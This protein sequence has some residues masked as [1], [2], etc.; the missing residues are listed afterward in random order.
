[1][2]VIKY[3]IKIHFII[4]IVLKSELSDSI[5]INKDIP[6]SFYIKISYKNKENDNCQG[7]ETKSNK[8]KMIS[9]NIDLN[10]EIIFFK[11]INYE[12]GFLYFTILLSL[13]KK[14][15]RFKQTKI[16]ISK[17]NLDKR[18]RVTMDY[19]IKS[20][21]IF[22]YIIT[23][24][25]EKLDY[26]M[27]KAKEKRT[28][29]TKN[30]NIF[31]FFND[32]NEEVSS[33]EEEFEEEKE[34]E[35]EKIIE[36]DNKNY[37]ENQEDLNEIKKI[38]TNNSLEINNLFDDTILDSSKIKLLSSENISILKPQK[39][40]NDI[41][42]GVYDTFCQGFFIASFPKKNGKIIE[43]SKN[44]RSICGHLICGKLPSMEPEIIYKYPLEDTKDLE[45]NNLCAS[46]CFPTG[47]KVCYNQ[48][49]RSIYKF[50][51]TNIFNQKGKKYYLAIYHFYYQL[52]TVT[53]NKIYSEHP[54]K[55]YL[56]NF[57]NN[58]YHSDEEKEKLEKDL[59]ECQELGFRDYV[60]IPYAIILVSKYPYINQMK[61][62]LN[63]IFII[64]SN[65]K[66]ILK[67]ENEELKNLFKSIINNIIVYLIKVIPIP[68]SNT[69]IIFNLPFSQY[70]IK[71][72]SPNKNNIRN[73][74]DIN[75]LNLLK[76]FNVENIILIFKLMLFEQK[77]LFIDNDYNR[78][79]KVIESFLY[80]LYPIEWI[81]T[82]IP[83]MSHQMTRYLQTF[84]PFIN[85]ISE[86]LFNKNAINALNEN[87]DLV[88]EIYIT[89]GQIK[90][91]N[92]D[93][94]ENDEISEIPEFIY[95][96]LFNE[97]SDLKEI[98]SNL[99]EKEKIQYYK[100]IN[101]IFSNIFL[102][103]NCIMLYDFMDFIFNISEANNN[104]DTE[105]LKRII[106]KKYKR[107]DSIF[108][109]D[110]IDSQIFLY[111]LTNIIYNKNE[112]SLFIN[113]LRNIHEK[114]II[115]HLKDK[116]TTWKNII[117]KIQLKDITSN[118]K[119]SLFNIPNHLQNSSF[120]NSIKKTYIIDYEKWSLINDNYNMKN[121]D[122]LNISKMSTNE[123]N[124]T[125]YI[126]ESDRVATD[127]LEINNNYY[128]ND[129]EYEKYIIPKDNE[130]I[131]NNSPYKD[132]R[133][134]SSMF[135]NNNVKASLINNF[136]KKVEIKYISTKSVQNFIEQKS[137][138]SINLKNEL[139][140]TDEE[141]ENIE[142]NIKEC[143][144][145]LFEDKWDIP[146][147]ECIK[148]V[149]Y[150]FGRRILC[151]IIFQK[152]FKI[153]QIMNDKCFLSLKKIFLNSLISICNINEN[154]E[155]LDFAVKITQ[156]AFCYCKESN[157]NILLI[158]ELQS[159]L[160]KDYF[161]WI[162][163]N[164]WNTWQNIDNYFA[165]NNYRVY[166]DLIKCDFLFKLLRLKIDKEFIINYLKE[167][168]EEKMLL[169]EESMNNNNKN[170][171]KEFN[172]LYAK[173][174]IEITKIVDLE[175]Y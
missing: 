147:E 34:K 8:I 100:S 134:N 110:L 124:N 14:S 112:Y 111:F 120:D 74:T 44:Y 37:S 17:L 161:M 82:S 67:N 97:L 95:K 23:D 83:I 88:F 38:K 71:I 46:I 163:K 129:N 15:K 60:Y 152:G 117:R 68:E 73:I 10:H 172:D 77:L 43:N 174:K 109:K 11:E 104:I 114:Y 52:D 170:E 53:Y 49:R 51:T 103:A 138:Y 98:Y 19:P 22:N 123:D 150:N 79:Y 50:F 30:E 131:S 119:L 122:N 40:S 41:K 65:H 75:F 157:N 16:K 32:E 58:I 118:K 133:S 63:N 145:Q 5:Y 59:E 29:Q 108:Y 113:M 87:E 116:P 153:T 127:L 66:N 115:T 28:P 162:K 175:E 76:Y 135:S 4:F 167:C 141:K 1:M 3:N 164:F 99:N 173:T 72:S 136:E 47:I 21:F 160:G 20:K 91:R 42:G 102:E 169:M 144:N 2:N 31:D 18:Q 36:L 24:N 6:Y 9:K 35:K 55:I 126:S 90:C 155:I 69:N 105:I 148:N 54:L 142:K 107:E 7:I 80:L 94:E 121:D 70:K 25:K 48:D 27:K 130:E 12:N 165:I 93:L 85:G 125:E 13:N 143:L 140:L 156:A 149:Y 84:L 26:F 81:H 64:L 89:K 96:K 106:I 61:T 159:R 57:G 39:I 171:S 139:E 101:H 86:D 33:E 158:D 132:S 128:L 45:L 78:L 168:L 146:I 56:R 151:K 154:Q 92:T 62:I 166:C 137:K